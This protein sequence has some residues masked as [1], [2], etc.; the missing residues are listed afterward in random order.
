MNTNPDRAA[1]S[2]ALWQ[3]AEHHTIAEWICCDPINPSHGLCVQGGMALRM[4]RALL[5]DDPEAAGTAPLLDAVLAVLPDQTDRAAVL[6]EVADFLRGLRATGTAATVQDIETELRR[7]AAEAR[8]CPRCGEDLATYAEDD[9]VWRTGDDR[10]YC[11]GE[12]V[13]AAHRAAEAPTTTKP[14]G[15]QPRHT[16]HDQKSAPGWDW[17]CQ[18]CSTLPD[19]ISPAARVGQDGAQPDRVPHLPGA[20]ELEEKLDLKPQ[21]PAKHGAL[22][23]IC[24]LPPGHPGMHTGSGPNGGAVWDGDAP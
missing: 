1:V 2:A 24:E 21:C 17:E 19:D 16:C 5:V 18:W 6:L 4:L 12:C 22:G 15:V 8:R 11:S 13:I 3:T 20:A 9:L 23:R 14:P 7:L 10:P